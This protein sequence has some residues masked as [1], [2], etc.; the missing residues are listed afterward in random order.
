MLAAW[1]SIRVAAYAIDCLMAAV[2]N[3][4]LPW[5][6]HGIFAAPGVLITVAIVVVPVGN[7]IRDR[8]RS[9]RSR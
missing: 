8:I 7:T 1:T 4:D 6:K 3:G 9:E 2:L 5:I